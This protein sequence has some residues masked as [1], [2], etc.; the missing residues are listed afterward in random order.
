MFCRDSKRNHVDQK[1]QYVGKHQ[2]K[3]P[4]IDIHRVMHALL[5]RPP[6]SAL[7]LHVRCFT[8]QAHTVLVALRFPP[9]TRPVSVILDLGGVSGST[10]QRR[11]STPGVTSLAGPIDVT[12]TDFRLRVW[13]KCRQ[14]HRG[15][16]VECSVCGNEIDTSVSRLKL[17]STC[18]LSETESLGIRRLPSRV[19]PTPRAL[20]LH[21]ATL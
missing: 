21:G 13:E 6:F 11:S 1:I 8:R 9:A 18:I 3:R 16:Q 5:S 17:H 2:P 4:G 10:G 7:P 14:A 20:V 15:V 19:L 12:D